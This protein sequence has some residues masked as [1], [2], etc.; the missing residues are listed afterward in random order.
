MIFVSTLGGFALFGATGFIVGPV[1]AAFLMALLEI[2]SREYLAEE[3]RERPVMPVV[4]EETL[5]GGRLASSPPPP[6]P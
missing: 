3:K 2:Y 6:A 5:A 4:M 1:I